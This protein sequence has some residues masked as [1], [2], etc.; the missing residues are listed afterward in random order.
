[1][2]VFSTLVAN[3]ERTVM[4]C[5]FCDVNIRLGQLSKTALMWRM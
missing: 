1:M 5:C 2:A 4:Q 3:E